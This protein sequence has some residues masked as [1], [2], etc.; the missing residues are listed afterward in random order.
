MALAGVLVE[1]PEA[2]SEGVV[3]AVTSTGLAFK[4]RVKQRLS[5]LS[6]LQAIDSNDEKYNPGV[7]EAVEAC[8]AQNRMTN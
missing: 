6:V 7:R 1:A 4:V 8:G 3:K 2:G 5:R